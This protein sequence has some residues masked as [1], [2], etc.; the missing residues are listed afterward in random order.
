M[1]TVFLGAVGPLLIVLHALLALVLG[2]SS[3]HQA[4]IAT[5]ALRGGALPGRLARLYYLIALCAYAATLLSGAL[6]YPRYRYFVRG[7]YL[8]RYA[9]WASNLF[10]FKE[11]LA[12]LGLP[13]AIGAFMVARELAP[14]RLPLPP[15]STTQPAGLPGA[16]LLY[17][18]FALG[19]S[20]ISVFNIIA[21]L[22]CTSVRGL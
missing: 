18:L 1:P 12:T 2:G 13:L 8:D 3:V 17:G 7:L 5:R 19:T 16:R 9:P 22:L 21:G 10:D 15:R 11:N 4:V 6:V 14:A 20:L